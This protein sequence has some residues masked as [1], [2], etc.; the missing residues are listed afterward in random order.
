MMWGSAH[1][2]IHV[3]KQGKELDSRHGSSIVTAIP[4]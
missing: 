2:I 1:N 3:K 4:V